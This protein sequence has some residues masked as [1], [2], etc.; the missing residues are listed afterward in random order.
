MADK[1]TIEQI[2]RLMSET[3]Q[4]W[5][6]DALRLSQEI[7]RVFELDEVQDII[8]D[9]QQ[10]D[11]MKFGRFNSNDFIYKDCMVYALQEFIDAVGQNLLSGHNGSVEHILVDG[12]VTDITMDGWNSVLAPG[13]A[14]SFTTQMLQEIDG[15]VE[16]V[17]RHKRVV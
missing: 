4:R 6:D 16:I 2:A 1:Q 15:K 12:W 5:S 10:D 11:F 13:N 14:H 3:L 17:W 9:S 8:N 7:D